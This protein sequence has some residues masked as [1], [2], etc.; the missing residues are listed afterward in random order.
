MKA[1]LISL[2]FLMQAPTD[3]LPDLS[4]PWSLQQCIDWAMEH[5]L[6]VAGSEIS[7]EGREIDNHSSRMSWLP[8]VNGSVGESFSFGRGLGG[9]NTYEKGNS[10]S[11][12]LSLGASMTLFDGLATPRRIQLSKLNLEAA[13]ADLG[14]ARDNIRVA[15]A[16][17]FVQS[18]YN[19]EL[20]DVARRQVS[21]DSLQTERLVQLE[22]S[23]KASPAEVAQQRAELGQ[24][25]LGATRAANNLHLSLLD[26]AQLLEL[27]SAEGFTIV[28]PEAAVEGIL[29]PAPESVYADAVAERD[30]I[31]AEELRRDASEWTVRMAKGA[32]LPSLSLSGGV[33]T[34]YYT[35]SAAPSASFFDQMKNNFSQFLGLSLSVPVFTGRQ[36]RNQV[37]AATLSQHYQTLQ[38]EQTKKTLFK[39]IQQAWSNAVAAQ[40]RYASGLEAAQAARD[41]FELVKGRYE[42]GKANVAEFAQ[43][44]DAMLR[45]DSEVVQAR[46]ELL[47]GA[48]LLDF[49]SSGEMTF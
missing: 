34:N 47:F 3:S 38:L 2:A 25:R 5:N 44:R 27:P 23:G 1:L 13:T 22:R 37:R 43:S 45:A 28:R 6:T 7:V 10:S 39:E 9:N 20:L 21:I 49:Y 42:N 33:G 31:R 17:A 29:L 32:F 19:L 12:S 11:T 24:S 15:V 16:Q 14:A 40:E 36:N 30:V 41:A 46:Y 4:R 48:R 18:L 8:S 35:M 26:L